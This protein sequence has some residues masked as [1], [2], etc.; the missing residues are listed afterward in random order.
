[1]WSALIRNIWIVIYLF[2]YFS[3]K[4]TR[5]L[6]TA[7]TLDGLTLEACG[8]LVSDFDKNETDLLYLPFVYMLSVDL[9]SMESDSDV[10]KMLHLAT[11]AVE[12][13]TQNSYSYELRVCEWLSYA[14]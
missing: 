10:E 12:K 6:K 3:D 14:K 9:L 2:I 5:G 1:M 4:R 13:F 11:Q 7:D 8:S